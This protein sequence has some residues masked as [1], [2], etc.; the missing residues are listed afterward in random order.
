MAKPRKKPVRKASA[1]RKKAPPSVQTIRFD[2]DSHGAQA[3]YVDVLD[4]STRDQSDLIA[5]AIQQSWDALDS[6]DP[7]QSDDE[8]DA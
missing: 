7:T 1:R 3:A 6:E 8:D 2:F 4:E 5:A